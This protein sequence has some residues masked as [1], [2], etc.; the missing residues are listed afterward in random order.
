[1]PATAA[2]AVDPAELTAAPAADGHGEESVVG[3]ATPW[4]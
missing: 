1:M 4:P 2:T 3:G